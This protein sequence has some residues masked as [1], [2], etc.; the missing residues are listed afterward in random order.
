MN[1]T[2][3][4]GEG[5]ILLGDAMRRGKEMGSQNQDHKKNGM[6]CVPHIGSFRVDSGGDPSRKK[7]F[8]EYFRVKNVR[9]PKERGI[10]VLRRGKGKEGRATGEG[11]GVPGV[12]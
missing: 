2:I 3:R 1:T 5:L 6:K 9:M 7:V 8:F 10:G 11:R 4:G 12:N